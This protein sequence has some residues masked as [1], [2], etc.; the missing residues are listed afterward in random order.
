MKHSRNH[1]IT[2]KKVIPEK[3]GYAVMN[4][5]AKLIIVNC[6]WLMLAVNGAN[7]E[8]EDIGAI[9]GSKATWLNFKWNDINN[10]RL[11]TNRAWKAL[12]KEEEKLIRVLE[13]KVMIGDKAVTSYVVKQKDEENYPIFFQVSDPESDIEAFQHFFNW[14]QQRYGDKFTYYDGTLKYVG[15]SLVFKVYQ[16]EINDTR[17]SLGLIGVSSEKRKEGQ[18]DILSSLINIGH[19]TVEKKQKPLILIKC[20]VSLEF[21]DGS[22]SKPNEAIYAIDE[23]TNTVKNLENV[24]LGLTVYLNE[25]SFHLETMNDN[26]KSIKQDINRIT[27][28]LTGR[29][30]DKQNNISSSLVGRCEKL[31]QGKRKF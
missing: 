10:S 23:N 28:S 16:W 6:C 12:N 27:G 17:I 31:E 25:N 8:E 4:L 13:S 7:A 1:L 20:N 30:I 15:S 29:F 5:I 11:Y 22:E 19:K 26:D 21:N 14:C 3:K 24:P 2:Y 9:L 18:K